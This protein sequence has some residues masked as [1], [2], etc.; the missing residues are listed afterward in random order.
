MLKWQEK[1]GKHLGFDNDTLMYIVDYD[2][3]EGWRWIDAFEG[4]SACGYVD[5]EDAK[6]G[7]ENDY[8]KYPKVLAEGAEPFLTP[9]GY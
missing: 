1:N 6:A 9:E 2:T 5:A 8:A 3:E 4:W 7:A